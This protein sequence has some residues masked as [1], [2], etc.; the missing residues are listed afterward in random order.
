LYIA[1]Y[2][3]TDLPL[4]PEVTICFADSVL[5]GNRTTKVSSTQMQGFGSP[6]YPKLATIGEHINVD[7]RFVR[8][9]ATDKFY[10]NTSLVTDVMDLVLFPGFKAEQLEALLGLP[11]VKGI[12][13][14][15]FGAG[16]APGYK[17][18]LEAIRIGIEQKHKVILNVTQCV[19][20]TVE[21]GLYAASSGLL[22]RGVISGL[23]MTAEA[24]LT[25][26]MWT[27]ATTAPDDLE[28]VQT[29]LQI[30]WRGEQSENLFD[31]RYTK[32]L[33]RESDPHE[34]IVSSASASSKFRKA[35]LNRAVL[36]ISDIG[37]E[38]WGADE[39]VELRV[40]V[41]LPS[42]DNTT[43]LN[44]PHYAGTFTCLSGESASLLMDV[45]ET[46]KV[47]TEDGRP[48]YINLLPVGKKVWCKGIYLALFAKAE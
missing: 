47:V 42:A 8:P 44:D 13:L 3:A 26:M 4:I 35:L 9:P 27:L 12:V 46:V 41:N 37:F 31:L 34:M 18:F 19:Q 23:D 29:Q 40:F 21:M 33:G 5:R 28:E 24:A 10:V 39:S 36:R 48:V 16:N 7:M 38:N 45:T 15:T 1:G 30:S 43:S 2:K 25:K 22:E 17:D 11:K 6:N 20:G 32:G 14:R